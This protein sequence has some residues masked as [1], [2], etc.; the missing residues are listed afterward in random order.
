MRNLNS[1]DFG[2]TVPSTANVIVNGDAFG[3]TGS[4]SCFTGPYGKLHKVL[5]A[6][7]TH[8]RS[9]CWPFH[10]PEDVA[11]EYGRF[12]LD[13]VACGYGRTIGNALRRVLQSS[14]AGHDPVTIRIDD[15][16]LLYE[17]VAFTN[18]TD[19]ESSTR[20]ISVP[21]G[22]EEEIERSRYILTLP[23]NWDGEGSPAYKRKTWDRAV[24]FIRR[25]AR[26]LWKATGLYLPTPEINHGPRGSVDIDWTVRDRALL[27]NVPEDTKSPCEYYGRS[28]CGDARG[29]ICLNHNN[30]PL[31]QW[32]L[33]D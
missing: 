24:N 27:V 21:Q 19:F 3:V 2:D 23:E 17:G 7:K 11:D 6:P 28:K 29:Q 22:I 1:N 12:V 4:Y 13:P 10:P 20:S 9:D 31:L 16:P 14:I 5:T 18:L 25:E 15:S 32:I 30:A 33:L 26:A 8:R